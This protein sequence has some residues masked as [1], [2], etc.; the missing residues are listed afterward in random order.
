MSARRLALTR[1]Y[2][3]MSRN[4][5]RGCPIPARRRV[6][7]VPA[8][9]RVRELGVLDVGAFSL[10]LRDLVLDPRQDLLEQGPRPATP[11]AA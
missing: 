10:V 9:V 2:P 6:D 1:C 8:L 7:G 3:G 5:G 4:P 11:A